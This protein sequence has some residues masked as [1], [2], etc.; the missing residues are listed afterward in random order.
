ME[1][2]IPSHSGEKAQDFNHSFT[3]LLR[4]WTSTSSPPQAGPPWVGL[5]WKVMVPLGWGSSWWTKATKEQ[6]RGPAYFF[7][8]LYASWS[9][10]TGKA[11]AVRS[12]PPEPSY[13]TLPPWC[14]M[15]S[16]LRVR[17]K[18]QLLEDDCVRKWVRVARKPTSTRTKDWP[19]IWNC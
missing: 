19:A 16:Q 12:H 1:N 11:T 2:L 17:V 15:D 3:T 9:T 18:P 10:K 6:Q 8:V 5:F 4:F 14:I 13:H 7:S